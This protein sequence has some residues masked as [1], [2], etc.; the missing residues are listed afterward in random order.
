[1]CKR[2]F[3]LAKSTEDSL[4]DFMSRNSNSNGRRNFEYSVFLSGMVK[5]RPLICNDLSESVSW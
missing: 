1:M 3:T 5:L 2:V 4:L